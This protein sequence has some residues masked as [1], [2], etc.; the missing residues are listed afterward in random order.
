MKGT[1]IRDMISIPR[2]YVFAYQKGGS[3][4]YEQA[5]PTLDDEVNALINI[6]ARWFEGTI[7]STT[8]GPAK[9]W[10][11]FLWDISDYNEFEDLFNISIFGIDNDGGEDTLA[12]NIVNKEYDLST[13]NA[14]VTLS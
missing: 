1:Q 8:I 3:T 7:G 10:N 12:T 4:I 13:I 6:E 11:K 5:A 9:T 2:P 14:S